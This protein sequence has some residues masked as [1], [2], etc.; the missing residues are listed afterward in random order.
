MSIPTGLPWGIVS[1]IETSHCNVNIMYQPVDRLTTRA[2]L[3]ISP[4]GMGRSCQNF[5]GAITGSLNWLPW[6]KVVPNC[7]SLKDLKAPFFFNRGNPWL[8]SHILTK[9]FSN[10]KRVCCSRAAFTCSS[11]GLVF[12]YAV[13]A[14]HWLEYVGKSPSAGIMY[15]ELLEQELIWPLRELYQSLRSF[16]AELYTLRHCSSDS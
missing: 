9:L 10:L 11:A 6:W 14:L 2:C 3:T 16:K 5:I 4:W 13:K 12:L 7:G 15:S 1:G 8:C